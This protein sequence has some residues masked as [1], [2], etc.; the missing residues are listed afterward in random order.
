MDYWQRLL[1]SLRLK[2]SPILTP[3][4]LAKQEQAAKLRRLDPSLQ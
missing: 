2:R 4:E 3:S 1:L